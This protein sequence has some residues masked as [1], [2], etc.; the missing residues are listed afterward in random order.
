MKKYLPLALIPILLAMLVIII[1][2]NKK[3]IES[4]VLT[5]NTNNSYLYS[6]DSTIDINIYL[7][8]DKHVLT[9]IDSYDSVYIRNSDSSKVLGLNLIEI[10]YSHNEEFLKENYNSYF[11]KF[12]LPNLTNNFYIE[13]AILDIILINNETYSFEIGLFSI[14]YVQNGYE[15]DWLNIDSKKDSTSDLSIN[16]IIIE[17]KDELKDIEEVLINEFE[18][19]NFSYV[20]KTLIVTLNSN[21]NLF[22]NNLP[23][24]IKTS[25]KTFYLNNHTYTKEFNLIQRAANILNIYEIN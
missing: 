8:N 21:D 17:T 24:V 9:N 2:D 4:K 1:I 12:D 23:I 10:L 3:E 5:I 19:L 25:S 20:N 16:K 14:Y 11:L 18:S 15:L 13:D 6:R 22:I 7:N